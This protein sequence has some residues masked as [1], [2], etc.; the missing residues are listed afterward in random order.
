ME[1]GG[2]VGGRRRRWGVVVVVKSKLIRLKVKWLYT[3]CTYFYFSYCS[4]EAFAS[5][6]PRGNVAQLGES[7]LLISI[8]ELVKKVSTISF[9]GF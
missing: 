6:G 7:F 8:F 2:G 5:D 9:S 4:E 1:E 3:Y